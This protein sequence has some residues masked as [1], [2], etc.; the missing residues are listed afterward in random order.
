MTSLKRTTRFRFWLWL[1]R[2]IGLIVPRRLRA[3]WRQE[4]EAELHHRET[5]LAEWD[6]LDWKNK[7]DLM[8]KSF[9]ALWDALLLQPRRWEDEMIQ[10]LRF[11]VRMLL[12]H[13]SFTFIAIITLA[14]GI[15]ANTAI[16][17]VVNALVFNPLPYPNPHELVWVTNDWRGNEIMGAGLLLTYQA[18]SQT[19]AHL[20]AF[21]AHTMTLTLQ[22]QTEQINRVSA[23]A[24][25]FP[26]LG[27]A[28]RLGRA[29]TPEEDQPGAP[30]VVV[31]SHDYWQRRF[32]GD[33]A[34][35]G[36][37]FPLGKEKWTVIGVMPPDFRFL[38]ERRTGGR[39]DIW[40]PLAIDTQ[41]EL[42][43]ES[44]VILENVFGRLKP[45]VSLEQARAELALLSRPLIE[46]HPETA[47]TEAKLIPLAERLVG[48]L[49]RAL[50][51]LFG[52]VGFVLLI[53]CANVANLLLAR[54]NVRQKEMA[55]RAALGAGRTR[56][57]RQL[58]TESLLLSVV[59]GAA[60]LLLAWFGVKALVAFPPEDF[61]QLNVSRLD[62]TVLSFTFV[63]TLLTSVVAGLIPAWQASRVDVNESLKDGARS[64]SL[65]Q[66]KSGR[67]VA[68][69]LVIGELAL[70]LVL[71]IG[72]GLL[73]NSFLRLRSVDPG[74]NPE[75]L[76]M[77]EISPRFEKYPSGSAQRTR[78]ERELFARLN[79]LP[80]V[81]AVAYSEKSPMADF[82]IIGRHRLTLVGR[83]PER[84][85]AKPLAEIH[86]VGP[87]YFRAMGAPLRAGRGFTEQDN[88]QASRVT[89]INESLARRHFAGADP[90]GQR[91]LDERKFELTIIGVVSDM[92][93]YG[94]ASE[95]D[96]EFYLPMLQ[97]PRFNGV[98]WAIRA[99]GDPLK[100]VPS[101]RQEVKTL[102]ADHF[103]GDAI[104]MEQ[105]LSDSL[106]P[107]R[108]Q[109]WLFG[110]F[111]TVA[112]VLAAVGVYGVISYS[113]SRQ[114]HEIGIRLALGAQRSDVLWQ[115]VR[116]GMKSA[117][118]GV[119]VGILAALWLT[120]LMESLLYNVKANDPATFALISLLLISVAFLAAY[121]PARRATKVDPMIALRHE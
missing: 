95:S 50:L 92:K 69:A 97:Y 28:P 62:G 30:H 105:R 60:G 94:L 1:I 98:C 36:Q 12:K 15:G 17:S 35:V 63:A 4:W 24:S 103:F 19:F 7:L 112:L 14:L 78:F 115:V 91:I 3:D 75:H 83:T 23:T 119:V 67:H 96:A 73:I 61:L 102:E 79:A 9:G 111:A 106:A 77:L 57:I 6:K 21:E 32:G 8:R 43:G 49:R 81:Q 55:I 120:R 5:Q 27:V 59:G 89:V 99:T 82:G 16:F 109:L 31:L 86:Y 42:K 100:L 44:S 72:A 54:A 71:L 117:F 66:R 70:T 56:L 85:E 40:V 29:F 25:L 51:V 65:F 11:G 80:G 90:I 108:F 26:T 114:T 46:A 39:I 37:E 84:E 33:P 104:T 113:V 38:P 47:G 34:V 121:L 74:Y 101:V 22:G 87:E 116:Q 45:G 118:T 64:A 76:L 18:Q 110:L 93:R 58:L 68:P 52:A 2:F 10:D 48:H 41:R 88:E 20:A 107:R 53:A 13:K